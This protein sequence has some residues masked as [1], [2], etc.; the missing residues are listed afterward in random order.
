MPATDMRARAVALASRGFRVFPLIPNGKRPVHE[1]WVETA[2]ADPEA[3]YRSWT[4]AVSDDPEPYNI[5]ILTGAP[6]NGDGRR[7]VVFDVD[8]KNGRDGGPVFEF[9]RECENLPEETLSVATPSGGEHHYYLA[10]AGITIGNSS[11]QLGSGLDVRAHR[12]YVVG[13]GSETSAGEYRELPETDIAE[14][15]GPYAERLQSRHPARDWDRKRPFRIIGELDEPHC[16]AHGVKYLRETAPDCP[17]GQQSKTLYDVALKLIDFGLSREMCL[18]IMQEH[19]NDKCSPAVGPDDMLGR[20]ENAWRFR[21]GD[22]GGEKPA[23]PAEEEFGPADLTP[24]DLSGF[25]VSAAKL[26]Q[27]PPKPRVWLVEGLIP[28]AQV[29]SLSGDGATGKSLLARQLAVATVAGEKWLGREVKTGGCLIVSAEDD[30]DEES[31][32]L[33]EITNVEQVDRSRLEGLEIVPLAGKDAVLAAQDYQRPGVVTATQLFRKLKDKVASMKPA[34]VILDTSADL[35]AG[36]EID[37]S[38]VRQFVGMLRGIAIENDCAVLLLSHPSQAGMA[39]GSGTSGSTAWSNSVRSR[40]YLRRVTDEKTKAE[41][42]ANMRV[43]G[44]MKSNYAASG[45]QIPMVWS[46]GR[47]VPVGQATT[48]EDQTKLFDHAPAVFLEMLGTEEFGSDKAGKYVTDSPR[49]RYAP[50]LF[51]ASPRAVEENLEEKHFVEAMRRLFAAGKIEVV[52]FSYRGK[53]YPRLAPVINL[54][55]AG[56]AQLGA[57]VAAA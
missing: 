41:P 19:Y 24:I 38:Q 45:E 44:V 25:T 26:L 14:I 42:N 51:A 8:R 46:A 36:N 40:L 43:L 17:A 47:F 18:D 50:K 53:Y 39:S 13:P 22:I 29:T 16:V 23:P 54:P 9:I 21:E 5:G 15:P 2:S 48:P 20:I 27:H 11:G 52:Q 32:R 12:G 7:L 6:M 4:E 1:K 55:A 49:G 35:F 30:I 56:G 37:R 34:L 31:R 3:V 33:T 10:P 28:N 57:Q